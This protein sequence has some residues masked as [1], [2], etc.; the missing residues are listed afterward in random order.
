MSSKMLISDWQNI[1]YFKP[2]ERWG[3]WTKIDSKVIYM[4]DIL[5]GKLNTPIYVSCGTQGSH[6]AGSMHYQGKALDLLFPNLLMSDMP[7]V[8]QEAEDV[9]YTGIGLYSEWELHGVK[10]PGMHVDTRDGK[11]ARWIGTDL[12]YLPF[13]Q[14]NLRK[15]FS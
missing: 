14:L 4:L 8:A 11:T 2:T 12:G 6:V 10:T 1:K 13:N 5:R 3:D 9:G 7:H 15:I